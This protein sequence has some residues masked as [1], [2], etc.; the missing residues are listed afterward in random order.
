[1]HTPCKSYMEAALHV[2]WYLKIIQDMVVSSQND[3]SLQ[4]FCHSDWAGCPTLCKSITN[5]C[6]YWD[7]FLSS[8]KQR[9]RKQYL[10]S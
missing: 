2:L 10:F 1:M 5:Y 4:V 8:G 9:D 6:I 3:L 7:L